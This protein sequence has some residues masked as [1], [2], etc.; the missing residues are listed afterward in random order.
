MALLVLGGLGGL[1]AGAYYLNHKT[2]VP[3]GCEDLQTGCSGCKD[4]SC[5]HHPSH[6]YKGDEQ[7]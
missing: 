7:V 6:S 2:P 4:F 5:G 3:E 1:Y